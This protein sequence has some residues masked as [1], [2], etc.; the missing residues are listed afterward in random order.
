MGIKKEKDNLVQNFQNIE[1]FTTDDLYSFFSQT[2]K[3]IKKTTVNWRIYE[4]VKQGVIKRIGRGVYSLGFERDYSWVIGDTQEKVTSLIKT[5]FPL[6]SF[7]CWSGGALMEFYQ[8]VAKNNFMVVEIEKEAVDS[9]YF[10]LKESYKNTFKNPSK[11]IMNSFVFENK[12]SLVIKVLVSESPLQVLKGIPVPTLEKILVDLCAD[13]EI[14]FF[15]QGIELVNIFRNAFDKYTI[16]INKM[17]R[18]AKRR[19]KKNEIEKILNQ[20]GG[21]LN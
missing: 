4:L 16:N 13:S 20:I 17:M 5:E 11:D 14:F 15:V 8:H 6:I 7:C 21:N 10:L 3:D 19:N 1:S 18:Y 2:E 12:N 9:V